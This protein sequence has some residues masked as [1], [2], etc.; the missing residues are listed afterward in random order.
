LKSHWHLILD[1]SLFLVM[2]I[3]LAAV[4]GLYFYRPD[5]PGFGIY[6]PPTVD[7]NNPPLELDYVVA[8]PLIKAKNGVLVRVAFKNNGSTAINDVNLDFSTTDA[9]FTVSQL[10]SADDSGRLTISGRSAILDRIRAG[11]SGE[12]LLLVYFNQKTQVRV[13]GWQ[14][15]SQ[16]VLAGQVLKETKNLSALKVAAELTA[17]AVAYYTSPQ[18]DQLGIGPVPPLVGIPTNYWIFW[19]ASSAG[20]FKNLVFSARLPQGVELATGRSLVAGD[21]NY[22][23]SSRQI[24]WRVPEIKGGDSIEH[25]GFEVQLIPTADQA[26]RILPLLSDI[27]YYGID[28]LTGEES[29]GRLSALDT[30]LAGDRFNSG[31]GT[32]AQP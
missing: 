29:S 14:A 25:L 6:S 28:T 3:L 23:T 13:I 17:K 7:L 24:I 19:E 4:A 26:G 5:L 2:I 32:V 21:F 31:Q 30:D 18:G 20:D 9:N 8:A 16:Y 10:K 11:E 1:L 15:Q 12:V 22:S 27:R